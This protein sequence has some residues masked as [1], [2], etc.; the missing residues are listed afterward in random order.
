MVEWQKWIY[1]QSFMTSGKGLTNQP[2][3]FYGP[4]GWK[5]GKKIAKINE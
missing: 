2:S 1:N 4:F 5:E 3:Y